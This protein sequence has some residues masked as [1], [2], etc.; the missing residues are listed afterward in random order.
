MRFYG[1]GGVIFMLES[2]CIAIHCGSVRA[3]SLPSPENHYLSWRL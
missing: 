3:D 1:D 2:S